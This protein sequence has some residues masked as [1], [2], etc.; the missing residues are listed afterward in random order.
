MKEFH[1]K[2]HR[3]KLDGGAGR[4]SFP[5]QRRSVAQNDEVEGSRLRQSRRSFM[6]RTALGMA[7]AGVSSISQTSCQ[8]ADPDRTPEPS[9]Y[10]H[11]TIFRDRHRYVLGPS[12]AVTHQGERVVAFNVGVMREV[13]AH[14]PRSYMHPP[15][16][17]EYRNV[18][19]RSTDQGATWDAPRV[20]PS[21]DW[22]GVENP[23]LCVLSNGD[24]LASVYRREFYP[25]ETAK[26]T[27]G[28][29]GAVDKVP[30]PWVVAHGGTYV[31][32]SRDGGRTWDETVEVDTSPHI[33]GYSP[34]GAVEL[35]DGTLLLPLTAADPFYADYF[36]EA[37]RE[38]ASLGNKRDEQGNV[39]PDVSVAF[40]CISRDGGRT[41]KETQEIARDK[42]VDFFEPTIVQLSSG[43]L[44]CHLRT[45]LD[46]GYYLYQV[47]SDDQGR[48]WSPP[49]QTPMWGYP[50][51]LVEL[52]D[53]RVL[54]V[55]GHRREPFGIRACTSN[56]EGE[57]W[58][59]ESELI[60][61][62]DLRNRN[63]GYP[64]AIVQEDGTVFT[65]YWGEDPEGVTTIQGSYFT[66]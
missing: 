63:L 39:K 18:I 50:A 60:L 15:H 5:T 9:P 40:V 35:K 14:S 62:D 12:V 42:E 56:D 51:H 57:S 29:L 66:P 13:G 45:D 17:P 28:L 37:G 4:P 36:E 61:R 16:D 52:L 34:R 54:S 23:G 8:D 3:Q 24:L 6:K 48:T 25:T 7:A 58:E 43:R 1:S 44:I 19:T 21:Y 64:T 47:V 27:A 10:R 49:K 46:G 59:I 65:A 2:T 31:H 33:S 26:K 53:R 20:F 22:Y 11:I 55:Y 32:R 38:G 41:W 30:Y